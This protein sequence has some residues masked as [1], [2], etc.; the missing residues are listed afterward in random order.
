M[1]VNVGEEEGV[2]DDEV[3]R[4]EFS[5]LLLQGWRDGERERERERDGEGG[6]LAGEIL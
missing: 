2:F 5:L 3:A 6:E 1:H 4:F